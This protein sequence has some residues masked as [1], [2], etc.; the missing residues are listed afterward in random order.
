MYT[1]SYQHP[2]HL[3]NI[4]HVRSAFLHLHW[5]LNP[6]VHPHLMGAWHAAPAGVSVIHFIF[7]CALATSQ[8]HPKSAGLG[9]CGALIVVWP[10]TWHASYPTLNTCWASA[11][12]VGGMFSISLTCWVNS[13]SLSPFTLLSELPRSYMMTINLAFLTVFTELTWHH[14]M[15]PMLSRLYVFPSRRMAKLRHIQSRHG[16]QEG[17]HI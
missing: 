10:H 11:S 12:C 6:L 14:H 13:T 7:H 5:L 1:F 9:N 16:M 3:H 4:V 15:H 2:S 17:H 8:V